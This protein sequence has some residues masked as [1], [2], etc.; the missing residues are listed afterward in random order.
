MAF[1]TIKYGLDINIAEYIEP[2]KPD[3]R[4]PFGPYVKAARKIAN[5]KK[6]ILNPNGVDKFISPNK[7]GRTNRKMKK[8]VVL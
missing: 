3:K 6:W 5:W 7:F 1:P 4:P 8:L 2:T